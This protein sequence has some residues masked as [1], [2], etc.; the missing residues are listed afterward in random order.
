MLRLSNIYTS[1]IIKLLLDVIFDIHYNLHLQIIAL[2]LL[3]L[4]VIREIF[5]LSCRVNLM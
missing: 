3:T 2:Y 4:G 5:E 1:T